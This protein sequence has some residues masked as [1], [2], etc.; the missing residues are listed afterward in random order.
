M[1]VAD[2]TEAGDPSLGRRLDTVQS[3][4]ETLERELT[5]ENRLRS[6]RIAK[7][8]RTQRWVIGLVLVGIM[9][10]VLGVIVGTTAFSAARTARDVQRTTAVNTVTA[11]LGVCL[12]QRSAADTAINASHQH[13]LI[14]A[15]KLEPKPRSPMVEAAVQS[16]LAELHASDV[17]T[18]RKRDCSPQGIAD[19]YSGRG[20]FEP[21]PKRP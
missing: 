3:T 12:Q 7:T 11:R 17:A 16:A 6:E 20:G 8:E 5:K 4:L 14:L 1:T 9:V 10:G 18:I 15:D 13:D 21:L 2:G 19:F